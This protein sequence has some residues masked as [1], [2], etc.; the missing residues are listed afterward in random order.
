MPIAANVRSDDCAHQVKFDAE[1]WFIR[2]SDEEI[3]NLAGAGWG[4]GYV[5]ERVVEYFDGKPDYEEVTD[6]F[7]YV[8]AHPKL[9]RVDTPGFQCSSIDETAALR[10]IDANRTH[11]FPL[12]SPRRWVRPMALSSR[13]YGADLQSAPLI[14]C[15]DLSRQAPRPLPDRDCYRDARQQ[16]AHAG[17]A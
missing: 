6:L 5:A 11:L 10:W 2:A 1:P 15:Y 13:A 4:D 3:L 9:G 12:G 17:D 8:A 14:D 16:A 7:E